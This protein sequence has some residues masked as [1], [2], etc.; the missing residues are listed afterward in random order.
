MQTVPGGG[1]DGGQGVHQAGPEASPLCEH[2]L[3]QLLRVALGEEAVI[4]AP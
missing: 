4:P 3:L 1:E 2:P